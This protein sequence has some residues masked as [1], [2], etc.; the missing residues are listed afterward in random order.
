[1]ACETAAALAHEPVACADAE[2][3]T[4]T[5][6][7]IAAVRA[8]L[9]GAYAA[10]KRLSE[11]RGST[12]AQRMADR[13]LLVQ[14]GLCAAYVAPSGAAAPEPTPTA[15]RDAALHPGVEGPAG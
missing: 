6:Q 7:Q 13:E 12:P 3:L 5:G 10:V 1:M 15:S 8:A 2:A 14:I 9:T 11:Q 4:M